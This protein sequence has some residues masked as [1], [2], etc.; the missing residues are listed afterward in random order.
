MKALR[1]AIRDKRV[2]VFFDLEG[3]QFT[4]E[5]IEIGAYYTLLHEDLSVKKIGKPFKVYVKPQNQ[6]GP[7]VSELTGITDKKLHD[8]GVLFP[9]AISE[10]RKYV[11]KFNDKAIFVAFGNQDTKILENSVFYNGDIGLDFVRQIKKNYLDFSQFISNYIKDDNGN[12]Y[13]LKNY[14]RLFQIP[15]EGQA[16]DA[17]ADAYNLMEL[18]RAFLKKKSLVRE[19]YEKTLFRMRHLPAPINKVIE[20]LHDGKTVSPEDFD[21]VVEEALE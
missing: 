14:L 18:Y 5:V 2:L 11:A 15:F 9:T 1:K 13:S 20:M 3:T 8:E 19:E 21:R 6:I 7:L 12:A 16:H 10:F 4:H 17:A